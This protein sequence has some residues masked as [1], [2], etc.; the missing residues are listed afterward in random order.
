MG[1]HKGFGLALVAEAL[2]GALTGAGTVSAD[3]PVD[4]QGVLAIAIDV[5][6]MRPL[7]DFAAEVESFLGYVRDVPAEAGAPPVRIPGESGAEEAAERER[8]GVP[9]QDFTWDALHRIAGELGV[10]P[11]FAREAF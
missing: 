2:A 5:G 9:V 1:G 8:D 4:D 11:P 3:P 7:D 10:A 6:R